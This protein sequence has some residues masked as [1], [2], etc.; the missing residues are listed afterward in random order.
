MARKT[1]IRDDCWRKRNDGGE[2]RLVND[3]GGVV[4]HATPLIERW[5]EACLHALA[6]ADPHG[7]HDC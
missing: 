6:T 5:R 7:A 1:M 2:S 3:D 4:P